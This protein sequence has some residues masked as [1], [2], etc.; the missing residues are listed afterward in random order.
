MRLLDALIQI[1]TRARTGGLEIDALWQYSRGF[2]SLHPLHCKSR[3]YCHF[4]GCFHPPICG[5]ESPTHFFVSVVTNEHVPFHH[6]L[7]QAIGE[8]DEKE[9]ASYVDE[10]GWSAPANHW[11][12]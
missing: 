3:T 9:H 8:D 5:C 4:A 6:P 1:M 2:D 7:L 11:L 10:G 12:V